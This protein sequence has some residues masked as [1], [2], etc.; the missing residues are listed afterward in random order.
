MHSPSF[1]EYL[2]GLINRWRGPN[3]T[4]VYP[5]NKETE[6]HHLQSRV[7]EGDFYVTITSQRIIYHTVFRRWWVRNR[8]KTVYEVVCKAPPEVMEQLDPVFF[9][10]KVYPL[11][12][13]RLLA[14]SP[15]AHLSAINAFLENALRSGELKTIDEIKTHL[16]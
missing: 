10:P 1:L 13:S 7:F 5:G 15:Y 14:W 11:L 12:C 3:H 2:G 6:F 8:F 16:K 9:K 4:R